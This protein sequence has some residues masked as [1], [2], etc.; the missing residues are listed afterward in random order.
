[1]FAKPLHICVSIGA[2]QY[3]MQKGHCQGRVAYGMD[4]H[5]Y[6]TQQV[7][8]TRPRLDS[9]SRHCLLLAFSRG[10]SFLYWIFEMCDYFPLPKNKAKPI[11][12]SLLH[13][14]VFIISKFHLPMKSYKARRILLV[15]VDCFYKAK[16]KYMHVYYVYNMYVSVYLL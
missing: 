15:K 9:Q 5:S 16:N 8:S 14:Q 7:C 1:M 11:C 3:V 6:Q 13:V 4:F 12:F 10:T 2:Q